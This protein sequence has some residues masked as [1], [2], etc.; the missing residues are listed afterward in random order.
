MSRYLVLA[1]FLLPGTSFAQKSSRP[2]QLEE[3]IKIAKEQSPAAQVATHTLRNRYWQYRTFRANYLPSLNLDATI[4]DFNQSISL[5][6][7]DDGTE[8]FQKTQQV[9][10]DVGLSLNQQVG[11]SGGRVF[12]RS[13]LPG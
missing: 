11:L 5:I 8:T 7:N 13:D 4:P 9:N 10:S 12:L 3:V 6:P 1:V 2:I